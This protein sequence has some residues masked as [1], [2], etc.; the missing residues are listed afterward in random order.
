M[1]PAADTAPILSIDAIT[2]RFEGVVSLADVTMTVGRN[3]I[4]TV[5]GPNG[6]GKTSLFNCLTGVYTPQVGSISYRPKSGRVVSL[7]GKSPH[8]I[9]A[10]GI[11]RTFQT[12]RLFAGLS[13]LDNTRIGTESSSH[14]GPIGAIFRSPRARREDRDAAERASELVEFVGLARQS[15][16][17]AGSLAYGDRRRLE[18][19]RALGTNPEVLL[20]DEP[21]AGTNPTE[22]VGLAELVNR[23]NRELGVTVLLIE[24]DMALVMSVAHRIYVLNFGRV[25]AEGTAKEI[26]EHPAV[27]EAYLGTSTKGAAT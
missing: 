27:I 26:Q 24:H 8:R 4:L 11:G 19:A 10:L 3:E 7:V 12:A 23:I 25:I 2:L 18:I 1:T 17:L 13:V 5:I 22:K 20:L 16:A 21:A 6:A 9:S 15:D 14:T